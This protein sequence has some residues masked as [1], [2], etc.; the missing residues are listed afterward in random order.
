[1]IHVSC[2]SCISK[3]KSNGFLHGIYMIYC[4][5]LLVKTTVFICFSCFSS[6]AH[7]PLPANHL[8]QCFEARRPNGHGVAPAD[9]TETDFKVTL[10]QHHVTTY[11]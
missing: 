5:Q 10:F 7:V 9:G 8:A 2:K 11:F 6:P 1:M 4:E 3:K